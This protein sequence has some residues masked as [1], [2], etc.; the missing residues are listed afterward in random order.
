MIFHIHTL[1]SRKLGLRTYLAVL[2]NNVLHHTQSYVC[3]QL[4]LLRIIGLGDCGLLCVSGVLSISALSHPQGLTHTCTT[5]PKHPAPLAESRITLC[6]QTPAHQLLY[7]STSAL[8]EH[9]ELWVQLA[10]LISIQS[11]SPS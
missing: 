2:H 8:M 5:S 7:Y 10:W 6:L 9:L 3:L 1:Y 4:P 11:D